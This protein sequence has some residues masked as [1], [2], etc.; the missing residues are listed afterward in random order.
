MGV[1]EIWVVVE[2]DVDCYCGVGTADV[3][4]VGTEFVFP[5]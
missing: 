4:R 2:V 5:G 3:V 1:C